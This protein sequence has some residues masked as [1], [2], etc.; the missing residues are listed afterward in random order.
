MSIF[1]S[2]EFIFFHFTPGPLFV[3]V[4]LASDIPR[5][6]HTLQH[7]FLVKHDA[8]N[9]SLWFLWQQQNVASASQKPINPVEVGTTFFF[10]CFLA[11]FFT[12]RPEQ[13]QTDL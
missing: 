10:F 11:F 7:N 9:K 3:D 12:T 4:A 8:K 1:F 13:L 6:W 5:H 2:W